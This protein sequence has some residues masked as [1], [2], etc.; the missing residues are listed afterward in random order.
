LCSHTH[1]LICSVLN[2]TLQITVQTHASY[3]TLPYDIL[4]LHYIQ[5]CT[6]V[7][8]TRTITYPTLP[9]IEN[10]TVIESVTWHTHYQEQQ[11]SYIHPCTHLPCRRLIWNRHWR[12]LIISMSVDLT[13]V[14]VMY[15]TD[16]DRDIQS[17]ACSRFIRPVMYRYRT[18][19]SVCPVLSL[20]QQTLVSRIDGGGVLL[21]PCQ[22]PN[23]TCMI[24]YCTLHP[25]DIVYCIDTVGQLERDS[26]HERMF[27]KYQCSNMCG[28]NHSY[29][30]YVHCTYVTLCYVIL[31]VPVPGEIMCTTR[32]IIIPWTSMM[33]E[34]CPYFPRMT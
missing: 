32:I 27:W 14:H 9:S 7:Q 1:L 13:Y 31:L 20:P 8:A 34:E 5:W 30:V 3:S 10:L 21:N 22:T 33:H 11:T 18:S 15:D 4:C 12:W 23:I 2:P 6:L 25:L 26:C 19:Q 29:M 28:C 17:T 24:S 16:R